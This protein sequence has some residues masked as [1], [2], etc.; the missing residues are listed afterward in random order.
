MNYMSMWAM[1]LTHSVWLCGAMRP[2][3]SLR[4]DLTERMGKHWK[5]ECETAV[6]VAFLLDGS[7]SVRDPDWAALKDFVSKTVSTFGFGPDKLQVGIVQYTDSAELMMDWQSDRAAVMSGI[8]ELKQEGG[9]TSAKA[10]LLETQHLFQKSQREA[11]R[12]LVL[13]SDGDV[14]SG[15]VELKQKM[16]SEDKVVFFSVAV[17]HEATSDLMDLASSKQLF[18]NVSNYNVLGRIAKKLSKYSC[19]VAE[20][21]PTTEVNKID[22]QETLKSTE[23]TVVTPDTP[24]SDEI[25]QAEPMEESI[26]TKVGSELPEDISPLESEVSLGKAKSD[27]L[28]EDVE[29]EETKPTSPED[30]EP[31]EDVETPE[32][33]EKPEQVKPPSP[34]MSLPAGLTASDI[35]DIPADQKPAKMGEVCKY[36]TWAWCNRGKVRGRNAGPSYRKDGHPLCCFKGSLPVETPEETEPKPMS[37][38]TNEE[39]PPMDDEM[40][41]TDKAEEPKP[42]SPMTN[43]EEPPMDDEMPEKDKAEEPKPMSPMTN[44]EEPPMDD[45]MPEVEDSKTDDEPRPE[46]STSFVSTGAGGTKPGYLPIGVPVVILPYEQGVDYGAMAGSGL[47]PP[48]TINHV[49][50][51][52]NTHVNLDNHKEHVHQHQE[53]VNQHQEVNHIEDNSLHMHDEEH[54]HEEEEM[55]ESSPS[56]AH[57]EAVPVKPEPT[58]EE[59]E[60]DLP[61]EWSDTPAVVDLKTEAE[62]PAPVDESPKDSQP[63]PELETEEDSTELDSKVHEDCYV[64][65]T[66]QLFSPVFEQW[67]LLASLA[68]RLKW[69]DMTGP[70]R[71]FQYV[72]VKNQSYA[73]VMIKNRKLSSIRSEK[74]FARTLGEHLEMAAKEVNFT[75][76]QLVKAEYLDWMKYEL[77]DM[78]YQQDEKNK[79]FINEIKDD[80]CYGMKSFLANVKKVSKGNPAVRDPATLWH[81]W[82]ESAGAVRVFIKVTTQCRIEIPPGTKSISAFMTKRNQDKWK[83][84]KGAIPF[85]PNEFP[86]AVMSCARSGEEDPRL[87]GTD[88]NRMVRYF[89]CGHNRMKIEPPTEKSPIENCEKN[90]DP[91]SPLG[92]FMS[93]MCSAAGITDKS[94]RLYGPFWGVYSHPGFSLYGYHSQKEKQECE[95]KKE[96]E[97]VTPD[98]LCAEPQAVAFREQGNVAMADYIYGTPPPLTVSRS[99]EWLK[100]N[101]KPMQTAW[102]PSEMAYPLPQDRRLDPPLWEMLREAEMGEGL[103]MVSYGYSGAG[104]TTTLIGDATAP[105]GEGTGIDGVLSLYLKENAKKIEDVQVRIFEVYGRVN[106]SYG[107]MQPGT[108]SGIWGYNLNEKVAKFLGAS[109]DFED[110]ID[111]V[112]DMKKL[113][114]VLD[115]DEFTYSVKEK[116]SASKMGDIAWHEKVKHVL[117]IIEDIRLDEGQFVL[118]D[119]KPI[120][121]IRGT[122]NNPKSSRGTLVVLTN[123]YFKSGEMS[124]ISTVD[125]AGSEDPAVM[126]SGFLRFKNN[127]GTDEA[128]NPLPCSRKSGK[129]PHD[130]MNMYLASLSNYEQMAGQLAYCFELKDVLVQCDRTKPERGCVD[131]PLANNTD[132]FVR[133]NLQKPNAVWQF[134]DPRGVGVGESIAL[135]GKPYDGL[136]KKRGWKMTFNRKTLLA[137]RGEGPV[138]G[139]SPLR[140]ETLTEIG[141]GPEYSWIE[142]IWGRKFVG[143]GDNRKLVESGP[144]VLDEKV[145][146]KSAGLDPKKYSEFMSDPERIGLVEVPKTLLASKSKYKKFH[147]EG[148]ASYKKVNHWKQERQRIFRQIIEYMK[149]LDAEAANEEFDRH[150]RYFARAI[151]PIV[152]EAF[153]IN[154]ALNDMKGYL[155]YWADQSSKS[156]MGALLNVW[157]PKVKGKDNYQTVNYDP[158]QPITVAGY[159]I[160]T[161]IKSAHAEESYA[162]QLM[163]GKDGIMLVTMLEYIRQLSVRR[164]R[165]TKVMVGTFIRSDIPGADL[166]CDGAKASLEFAQELSEGVGWSRKQGIWHQ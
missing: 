117:T 132:A 106:A 74:G 73:N 11:R 66:Y 160:Y 59:K 163:R 161:F 38:M 133:P 150:L 166:A 110:E 83:K 14:D 146:G 104:K 81:F 20:V 87:R 7:W 100:G 16:E 65:E 147:P 123:V 64:T 140:S 18:F 12:L 9:Y 113:E 107:H 50:N 162:Q 120:A 84:C 142:R 82:Q 22:F 36:M 155:G 62:D 54:D 24:A 85:K 43:E 129:Q 48:A 139:V 115:N 40:P 31:P 86:S 49:H 77:A 69:E 135:E 21:A 97:G 25:P 6:D 109:S 46:P 138:E 114:S 148:D 61:E 91:A 35:V 10:G 72:V 23:S 39:E 32:S 78:Y 99:E 41:E 125:L 118:P 63:E 95:A 57:Q 105:V 108:G 141:V 2:A 27:D 158:G 128:G 67:L 15:A 52:H 119:G 51:V 17:G 154:E 93:E 29:P 53:V 33:P 55:A 143:K 13:I 127:D 101:K 34:E 121:H 8:K 94:C 98:E 90:L 4:A 102:I 71:T 103:M 116:S 131:V 80:L 159:N 19:E 144:A 58:P 26:K 122:V 47:P 76:A 75:N 145:L 92:N 28:P 156:E 124:P 126:V 37:P 96:Q 134:K 153:F 136:D 45:E 30:V 88:R 137:A 56:K 112:L 89:G 164:Q 1:V 111:G 157:P 70:L 42:M 151:G 60:A 165:N 44:E 3:I 79:K 152:E 68:N 130:F 5:E 149:D